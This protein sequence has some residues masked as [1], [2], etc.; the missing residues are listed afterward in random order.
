[1]DN[2]EPKLPHNKEPFDRLLR[3]KR[4]L[5]ISILAIF[6]VAML[7]VPRRNR[8]ITIII[9]LV[10]A[11]GGFLGLELLRVRIYWRDLRERRDI[12]HR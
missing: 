8:E 11:F 3:Q 12:P 4:R 5:G 7:L 10:V 6:P 1:M 2:Y 9:L